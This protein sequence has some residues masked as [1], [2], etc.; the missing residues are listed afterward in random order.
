MATIEDLLRDLRQ[1]PETVQEGVDRALIGDSVDVADINRDQL[2]KGLDINNNPFGTYAESTKKIRSKRG[3]QTG[4]IDLDFT[5]R[6]KRSIDVKKKNNS[7]YNVVSNPQWDQQ[8]FPDAIGIPKDGEDELT[9]IITLN[10]E[11]LLDQ[12]FL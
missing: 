9:N 7:R 8:R 10:I 11:S 1:L 12:K 2:S 4:F 5:G 6:S 3:L